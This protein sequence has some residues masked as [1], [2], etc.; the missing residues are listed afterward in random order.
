MVQHDVGGRLGQQ[1]WVCVLLDLFVQERF[2][3]LGREKG[4]ALNGWRAAPPAVAVA[5]VGV[6]TVLVFVVPFWFD[7]A[8]VVLSLWPI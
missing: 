5:T 6:G 7:L 4:R 1:V 8:P 2:Q 3:E